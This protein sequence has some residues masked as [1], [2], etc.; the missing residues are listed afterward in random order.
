MPNPC[1]PWKD[2]PESFSRILLY[3]GLAFLTLFFPAFVAAAMSLRSRDLKSR[4]IVTTYVRRRTMWSAGASSRTPKKKRPSRTG[5]LTGDLMLLNLRFDR[6]RRRLRPCRSAAHLADFKP[7]KAPD[8]NVLAKLCD[9]LSDHF[10]DGH[11]LVLDV[12]LFVET[13]F[14]VELFHL[15]VDDFLDNRLGLAGCQRL[16][17]VNI[18]FLLEHLRGHFFAP[19]IAGI[20][21]RDVHGDVMRELLEGLRARHKVR[22]AVQLHHYAD[23]PARVDVAADQSFAGFAL[24]FLRGRSLTLLPENLD[25]LLDHAVRF[26]ERRAAIRKTGAGPLAQFF[27]KLRWNFHSCRLC[28]HPFFSFLLSNFFF[29]PLPY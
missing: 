19:H 10:T 4:G 24:C 21:R 27:N 23:F 2:S 11:A 22:L 12:V 8:R 13:I 20:E 15:S 3:A 29:S 6:Y 28:T 1:G 16:R 25:S 14:L 18:A 26:H 7:H 5:T 17:L 9:S